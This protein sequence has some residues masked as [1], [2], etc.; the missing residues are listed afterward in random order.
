[1]RVLI[2][3][4]GGF[5]A[6]YIASALR[7][8]L[9]S[10]LEIVG[11]HHRPSAGKDDVETVDVNDLSA[12]DRV[13]A[14]FRPDHVIHLAA[15]SQVSDAAADIDRA[16]RT[17]VLGTLNCAK[18]VL[19]FAGN[20]SFIFASSGQIYGFGAR[21]HTE[22]CPIA[23]INDYAATKAAADIALGALAMRGLRA[24]RLRLYNHTGPRQAEKFVVPNFAAQIARIE[25]KRQP[26]I[27]KV[28]NL[29]AE[30]DFLDV[31]DVADAYARTV[32]MAEELP[33]GTVLN[34][35]SGQPV[36]IGALLDR[37]IALASEPIKVQ[38][39]PD[40]CRKLDLPSS[41]GNPARCR[42]VLNWEPH[43]SLQQTLSDILDYH[44]QS[45]A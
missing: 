35:C 27:L 37:L 45:L 3:G 22:D 2:T 24:V 12:V 17:N 8:L 39:D 20:A 16:W 31:R 19:K 6:P 14:G 28:G 38:I 43:Y 23:P 34:V 11:T 21:A 5:V 40:R 33:P 41:Y 18:A 7:N 1:M 26:A 36:K 10:S 29:E 15:M 13:L 42:H 9:G 4:Y 44:R 32:L 30:R 25:Q